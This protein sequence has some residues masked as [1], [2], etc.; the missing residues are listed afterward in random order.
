MIREEQHSWLIFIFVA[1]AVPTIVAWGMPGSLELYFALL[2]WQQALFIFGGL[3]G[4]RFV[5]RQPFRLQTLFWGLACGVGLFF[6][7]ALIGS[8]NFQLIAHFV[9]LETAQKLILQE[10]VGIHAFLQ[11]DQPL[12]VTGVIVLLTV[13]APIGEELFFRRFLITSWSPVL[14]TKWA[15][16]LSSLLFAV[17]H[18][19]LIQFIP[20]LLAGIALGLI[21][22]RT[23]NILIPIIAHSV[24]NTVVLFVQLNGL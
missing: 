13:G 14:S 9:G 12:I 6:F 17:L 22:V 16:F 20:V 4:S 19:Y 1:W 18:F 2:V 8:L 3:W 7:N 24:V 10:R 21:Y 15:V 11:S 23:N 5:K